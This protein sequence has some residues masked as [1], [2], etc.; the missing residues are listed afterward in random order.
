MYVAI[1][2]KHK[3]QGITQG[4]MQNA[5]LSMGYF[6]ELHH[7]GESLRRC[8]DQGLGDA[9]AHPTFLKLLRELL[10]EVACNY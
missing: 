6:N 9:I 2:V 1:N 4:L 7:E 3:Y 8:Q 5:V 10:H